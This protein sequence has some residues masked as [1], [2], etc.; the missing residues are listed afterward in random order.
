[1]AVITIAAALGATLPPR[2]RPCMAWQCMARPMPWRPATTATTTHARAC[3]GSI[4]RLPGC[5][6][7]GGRMVLNNDDVRLWVRDGYMYLIRCQPTR[8]TLAHVCLDLISSLSRSARR[9]GLL[10]PALC[11]AARERLW[12]ANNLPRLRCDDLATWTVFAT[13]EECSDGATPRR[14]F[15]WRVRCCAREELLL[16]LLP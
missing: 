4:R 8:P 16:Q 6:R 10:D 3:D 7:Q 5:L 13:D 12:A 14:R 1:M 15:S 11:A 2:A 9:R